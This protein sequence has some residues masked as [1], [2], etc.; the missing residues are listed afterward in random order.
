MIEIKS[1]ILIW[2]S[3]KRRIPHE[4]LISQTKQA[5]WKHKQSG[6]CCAE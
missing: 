1:E 3:L 6:T 5:Y 2:P 4:I